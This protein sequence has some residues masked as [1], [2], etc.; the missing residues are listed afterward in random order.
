MVAAIILIGGTLVRLVGITQPAASEGSWRETDGLAIARNLH[1]DVGSFLAPVVDWT[2]GAPVATE[3]PFLPWIVSQIYGLS[4]PNEA[5]ARGVIVAF[6]MLLMVAMWRIGR[7]FVGPLGGLTALLIVA[8]HPLPA[9]YGRTFLPDVPALALGLTALWVYLGALDTQGRAAWARYALCAALLV[10]AVGIKPPALLLGGVFVAATV[11]HSGWRRLLSPPVLIVGAAALLPVLWLALHERSIYDATG[12]TFGIFLGHN[13]FHPELTLTARFWDEMGPRL[14]SQTVPLAL[15]PAVLLGV[16]GV[17]V[18][19]RRH[20]VVAVWVGLALLWL[21]LVA[22]GNLDMPHYQLQ[23]VPAVALLCGAA[24]HTVESVQFI[25]ARNRL[26]LGAALA[27]SLALGSFS[28][29]R[30]AHRSLQIHHDFLDDAEVVDAALPDGAKVLLLGGNTHY[31]DGDDFDP[32]PF[33]HTSTN[34][35]VLN[36]AGYT[37]AALSA[38]CHA[39]ARYVLVRRPDPHL[40]RETADHAPAALDLVSW[41]AVQ[42]PLVD[43]RHLT[44]YALSC[45]GLP[46]PQF[47][48]PRVPG[49]HARPDAGS[50]RIVQADP[51]N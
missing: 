11:S 48:W 18:H 28:G 50:W 34:G 1:L 29:L 37:L 7:R 47:L 6:S 31:S 39:G 35:W 9:Y 8:V 32:R 43:T 25:D 27:A 51:A 38:Y 15:M 36:D 30:Y 3:V 41:L 19:A 40:A 42:E 44:A 23:V 20:A 22:E 33:Y 26:V 45:E 14:L 10:V 4:G 2:G 21:G 46:A 13:K 5:V 24:V 12:N 49:T 16:V 17:V